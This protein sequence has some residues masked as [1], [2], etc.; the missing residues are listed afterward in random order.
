MIS[1]EMREEKRTE[2]SFQ[3]RKKTKLLFLKHAK[4]FLRIKIFLRVKNQRIKNRLKRVNKSFEKKTL[5]F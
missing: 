5:V 1:A 3:M 2:E 4:N